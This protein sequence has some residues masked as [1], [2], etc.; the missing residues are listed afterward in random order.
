MIKRYVHRNFLRQFV[1]LTRSGDPGERSYVKAI[2]HRVY[3]KAVTYRKF[4]RRCMDYVFL[5]YVDD[6][7][8]YPPY[9]GLDDLLEIYYS[10]IDGFNV[11]LKEEHHEFFVKV[12][13]PLHK[14]RFYANIKDSVIQC[15]KAYLEK[16]SSVSILWVQAL[17]KWWPRR[18]SAK[19]ICF[20]H[21]LKMILD[22]ISPSN[23]VKM[24]P[25]LFKLLGE[26]MLDSNFQI[27]EQT[28]L[29]WRS[30][31][32][33]SLVA[34]NRK[35]ILPKIFPALQKNAKSHWHPLIKSLSINVLKLFNE[36]D[37]WLVTRCNEVLKEEKSRQKKLEKM[38]RKRNKKVNSVVR[39]KNSI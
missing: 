27:A 14:M 13:L 4:L 23:F 5:A 26:C 1:D 34:Q 29:C 20:F 24:I 39:S 8:L 9:P 7:G 21:E 28:L 32:F 31:Y 22:L 38:R 15:T 19:A 10:I 36:I 25:D 33:V 2:L 35:E 6:G 17:L 37:P 12:L 18:N 30:E 11:P 3:E 16:D